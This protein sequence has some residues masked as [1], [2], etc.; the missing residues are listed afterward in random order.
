MIKKILFPVSIIL[1][2][3]TCLHA[4]SPTADF[5]I[6]PQGGCAPVTI[7]FQ[8]QST[9]GTSEIVK[10]TWSFGDGETSNEQNPSH[11]YDQPGDYYVIFE[12]EDANDLSD[13][14]DVDISV[15]EPP[16]VSFSGTPRSAIDT[17]LVVNFSANVSSPSGNTIS[18][19]LWIFGD[20]DSSF[21]QDPIHKYTAFGSYDVTLIATDDAGCSSKLTKPSYININELK[22]IIEGPDTVCIGEEFT[23]SN[24]STGA[25]TCFWTSPIHGIVSGC[26]DVSF[27]DTTSGWHQL[28]LQIFGSGSTHDTTISYYVEDPYANFSM[29]T[30]KTCSYPITVNFTDQS[31]S[32]VKEWEWDFGDGGTSSE[33][34]PTHTYTGEPGTG[35]SFPVELSITTYTGCTADSIMPFL[36]MHPDI[37]MDIDT[38]GCIPLPV[39]ISD[40]TDWENDTSYFTTPEE[41]IFKIY[42]P[43][44]LSNIYY[45]EQHSP[46]PDNIQKLFDKP[47]EYPAQLVIWDDICGWDSSSLQTILVGDTLRLMID[48]TVFG[49][50][51]LNGNNL[52]VVK[53]NNYRF[54]ITNNDTVRADEAEWFFPY[55]DTIIDDDIET[56]TSGNIDHDF[57]NPEPTI[58]QITTKPGKD[59]NY[60]PYYKVISNIPDSMA[61]KTIDIGVTVQH[62][63]CYYDTVYMPVKLHGPIAN[64]EDVSFDCTDPLTYSFEGKLDNNESYEAEWEYL[65]LSDGYDTTLPALKQGSFSTD[66]Y[67]TDAQTEDNIYV[68]EV[69]LRAED[70]NVS[71]CVHEVSYRRF[72][73]DGNEIVDYYVHIDENTYFDYDTRICWDDALNAFADTNSNIDNYLWHIERDGVQI[74]PTFPSPTPYWDTI[75]APGGSDFS[76]TFNK[77][78][79]FS[80]DLKVI[81]KNFCIETASNTV[82]AY[83]PYVDFKADDTVGC[84]PS[85]DVVFDTLFDDVT[86]DTNYVEWKWILDTDNT[87]DSI[88]TNGTPA[89]VN[90]TYSPEEPSFFR[91]RLEITD[92]LGCVAGL[93]KNRYILVTIPMPDFQ[94][95]TNVCEQQKFVFKNTSDS[96]GT[97]LSYEWHFGDDTTSNDYS[98]THTYLDTGDYT[99]KLYA[100]DTFGCVDSIIK[101]D[102][103]HTKNIPEAGFFAKDTYTPCYPLIGAFLDTSDAKGDTIVQY[104]WIYGDGQERIY[105]VKQ[106]TFINNYRLPGFYDVEL[107]ITT[108][109]GCKDTLFK[110]KYMEVGG[111]YADFHIERPRE[112]L[113]LNKAC[114]SD[115]IRFVFDTVLEGSFFKYIW[116]YDVSKPTGADMKNSTDTI[117]NV[118]DTATHSDLVPGKYTYPG[119]GTRYS[120]LELIGEG[121]CFAYYPIDPQVRESYDSIEIVPLTAEFQRGDSA[122]GFNAPV[123]FNM[124]E[125]AYPVKWKWTFGDG[126][127]DSTNL[128]PLH[129][130]QDTGKYLAKLYVEG[131]VYGCVDTVKQTIKVFHNPYSNLRP[132]DTLI[133]DYDTVYLHTFDTS[134]YSYAWNSQ[135]HL[136]ASNKANAK[137]SPDETANYYVTVTDDYTTCTTVDTSVIFVQRR[138]DAEFYYVDPMKDTVRTEGE[139]FVPLGDTLDFFVVPNQPKVD[140]E[141]ADLDT[142]QQY[143]TPYN[144]KDYTVYL[145]DSIRCYNIP[146]IINIIV[147]D[148]SLDLPTAFTPNGDGVNDVIKFDGWGLSELLDF[149]IFNRWGQQLFQTRDMNTGW[150]GTF[151]GKKQPID[152][153]VY[154][155]KI[156]T[157]KGNTITK[158][159]TFTLMR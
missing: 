4:Q 78:G 82:L 20:G 63:E 65:N 113:P 142:T 85:L 75:S 126:A 21:V 74:Y 35:T 48:T 34:N 60:R 84:M 49:T 87:V 149:R 153:Y 121:N 55:L 61:G 68:K 43:Q 128:D 67:Y 23:M 105:N 57:Y 64:V 12:I 127:F 156:K 124:I 47:G 45:Q 56:D 104:H 101:E 129:I 132:E 1:L 159:G 51:L 107:R 25:T 100:L 81:K 3:F 122:C 70:V 99:V 79:T 9:E 106:D 7:Q 117:T 14:E 16:D 72:S 17:P 111:P 18:D 54:I 145:K 102:Y 62:N 30:S 120:Y 103:I 44:S 154:K 31:I 140:V 90:Y 58:T 110:E 66:Y 152:T 119:T 150:D 98:P 32:T 130:Y 42:Q 92:K 144:S 27:T 46:D 136:V 29:D 80:V 96:L 109:F 76:K 77:R 133:C 50:P 28:T 38:S 157:L 37:I 123:Q 52:C 147:S 22:A 125:E 146:K 151:N 148:G 33:K 8:D 137:A 131:G 15:S 138:P 143:F 73:S 39:T 2:Q 40:L 114:K 91:P 134:G 53:N 158:Q 89:S 69:K 97:S 41:R 36:D 95:D 139:I 5:T 116:H 26:E 13:K 115:T 141:W 112:D 19:Y 88:V 118:P 10:Y 86:P 59:G 108:Q 6:S 135:G 11:T 24:A 93:T 71:G 83:K 94:T 155:V